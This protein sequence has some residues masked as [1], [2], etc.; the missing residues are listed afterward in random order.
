MMSP[1]EIEARKEADQI[2]A[3]GSIDKSQSQ[4]VR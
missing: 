3:G 2:N 4:R 1:E